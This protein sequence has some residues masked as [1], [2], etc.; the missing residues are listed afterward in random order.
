MR[1]TLAR[2]AGGCRGGSGRGLYYK[3]N[4]VVS[5]SSNAPGCFKAVCLWNYKIILPP[6]IA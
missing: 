1:Q 4:S 2:G 5:R 3:L 6:D